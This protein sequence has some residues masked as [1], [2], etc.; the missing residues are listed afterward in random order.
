VV[1]S[2][3]IS[4]NIIF[5]KSKDG[6]AQAA[7]KYFT[8][9]LSI[10][11]ILFL[12]PKFIILKDVSFSEANPPNNEQI[13]IIP[14]IRLDFSLWELLIKRRLFITDIRFS[15][16]WMNYHRF[17]GFLRDNFRQIIAFIQDL[18]LQDIKFYIKEAALDLAQKD[19]SHNFF[20]A[21]F[22]LIIK[23]YSVCGYGS[24]SKDTEEFFSA[25]GKK[26]TRLMR[27][28]ASKYSFKGLLKIDGLVLE[29][30]ELIRENLYSKLWG[31]AKGSVFRLK[32]FT[33]VNTLFKD[34]YYQEPRFNI[35]DRLNLLLRRFRASAVVELPEANL[36]ILDINSQINFTFPKVTVDRLTFS[37]NN[38][39][40]SV[41]GG[42]LLSEPVSLDLMLSSYLANLKDAPTE[43]IK[44]IDLGIKGT[45][46]DRLFFGDGSL[47]ID[48]VKKVKDSPPLEKLEI[49]F[50]GLNSC[51][52]EYPH[53][54]IK[55]KEG[56]VFCKTDSNEYR[57]F[58]KDFNG[59]LNLGNER[60]KTIEFSSLL[61]DGFLKGR[62]SF[63][64]AQSP[65]NITSIIRVR[66]VS[67]NNLSGILVHFSKVSG[68][69][70]SQL[71]FRNYPKLELKGGLNVQNGYLNDFEFFKW[72]A[73]LFELP[74]L[75]R[76]YFSRALSNFLVNTEGAGLRGINLDSKNVSLKGYFTLGKNDWVSSKLSLVLTKDL[77]KESPKF[78]PL[79]RLLS[80]DLT[81]LH[82]NFQLSGDLHGMNFQWLKSDLKKELEDSIPGFIQRKLERD[83]EDAI[84]AISPQ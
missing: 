38:I 56:N 47:N 10:G 31:S 62:G 83:L 36:Y 3:T 6:I 40:F 60:F 50:K 55:I 14:T 32:G 46:K 20:S 74:T 25:N 22:T 12:P 73:E 61:Y 48:F 82:F 59:L 66:N 16:P 65:P 15:K 76:V 54:N 30:L 29:N 33:F 80:K 42:I 67:A 21:N 84:S 27:G 53:L 13:F 35:I 78:T 81:N 51:Y 41:K 45:L 52:A 34:T 57:I 72:L 23:G 77:L 17:F 39:P 69:L 63:D 75:K 71:Y 43:N 44:R 24:V 64:L 70:N 8:Q 49:G 9:K 37:V 79:L 18:P 68:R 11:N 4:V 26:I 19:S 28:P 58:L 1:L 5:S 7:E 2:A